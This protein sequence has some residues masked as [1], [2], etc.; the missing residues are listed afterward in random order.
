MARSKVR[1]DHRA[2]ESLLKSSD[3]RKYVND[4]AEQVADRVRQQGIEVEGIPGD[5]DL[6]VKVVE[7]TTDRAR[8]SV[9]LAHPSGIAVQAKHGSLSKAA[10]AEGLEVRGD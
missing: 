9:V 6:P 3:V 10:A 7:Q 5:I 2:L 4:A 1:L 8:A